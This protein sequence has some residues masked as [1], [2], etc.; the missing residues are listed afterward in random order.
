MFKCVFKLKRHLVP[1]LKVNFYD[2]NLLFLFDIYVRFFVTVFVIIFCMSPPLV[3]FPENMTHS[4]LTSYMTDSVLRYVEDEIDI[5]C[6]RYIRRTRSRSVSWPQ[7]A[8]S[9]FT[10]EV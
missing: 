1:C 5:D 2:S 6:L 10:S 3:T 9:A 7:A 8:A 4:L